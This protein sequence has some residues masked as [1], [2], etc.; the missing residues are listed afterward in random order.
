MLH[1]PWQ[2]PRAAAPS[3]CRTSGAAERRVFDRDRGW[4]M[5]MATDPGR[6]LRGLARWL[7]GGDGAEP[8]AP[9]GRA[10]PGAVRVVLPQ[11]R[12]FREIQ[13]RARRLT[14]GPD[15]RLR[16][17][18][19]R[20]LSK[21]AFVLGAEH[22]RPDPRANGR[23]DRWAGIVGCDRSAPCARRPSCSRTIRERR[24]RSTAVDDV[25]LHHR[26]RRSRVAA[27][28]A[29]GWAEETSRS[30]G[31]VTRPCR[32]T[33]AQATSTRNPPRPWRPSRS[34]R[35]ERSSRASSLRSLGYRTTERV[36]TRSA[37]RM[38]CSHA[39]NPEALD[40]ARGVDRLDGRHAGQRGHR[41]SP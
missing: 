29:G 30:S 2:G 36:P 13:R 14:H 10:G 27:C 35:A 7:R 34:V 8:G 23:I 18:R 16:A 26:R 41:R 11:S 40:R 21:C 17:A 39:V 15:E 1:P 25:P 20:R 19:N 32:N 12:T 33:S 4:R 3:R 6:R 9:A 28:T 38:S 24:S 37:P 31:G 5:R 22:V